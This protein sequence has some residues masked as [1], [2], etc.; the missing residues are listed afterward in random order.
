MA[1][2]LAGRQP[3]RIKAAL[4]EYWRRAAQRGALFVPDRTYDSRLRS[5]LG[6]GQGS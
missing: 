4:N 3:P 6:M 5:R 2:L 1:E